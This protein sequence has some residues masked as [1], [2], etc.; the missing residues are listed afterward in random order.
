MPASAAQRL[1]VSHRIPNLLIRNFDISLAF[2][3]CRA[4]MRNL[5]RMM[6]DGG[7]L[8]MNLAEKTYQLFNHAIILIMYRIYIYTHDKDI[9]GP[10]SW[11]LDSNYL[12]ESCLK[13]K[14]VRLR[15]ASENDRKERKEGL[16][17][18][19]AWTAHAQ[20]TCRSCRFFHLKQ[21]GRA[22]WAG[23]WSWSPEKQ[24]RQFLICS[25]FREVACIPAFLWQSNI[26]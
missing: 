16:G 6:G 18:A 14:A 23:L 21:G 12:G 1:E 7:R 2:L 10:S 26:V 8:E 15:K 20:G 13:F 25:I 9:Q 17:L 11:Q 3:Q 22:R 4:R 19:A 24:P 5:T